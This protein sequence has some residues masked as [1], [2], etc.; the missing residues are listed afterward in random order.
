MVRFSISYGATALG[1]RKIPKKL[2]CRVL[3]ETAATIS[4]IHVSLFVWLVA[5]GWC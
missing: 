4:L 5:D 3:A 2:E 1:R